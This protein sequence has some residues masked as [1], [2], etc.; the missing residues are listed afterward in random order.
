ML[1]LRMLHTAEQVLVKTYFEELSKDKP[2]NRR[3]LTALPQRQIRIPDAIITT[4]M[5]E[6]QL[7][8]VM[9]TRAHETAKQPLVNAKKAEQGKTNKYAKFKQKC[10]VEDARDPRLQREVIPIV[11]ESHGAAAPATIEH[12]A[13][14]RHH[15]GHLVLPVEDNSSTQIFFSTWTHQVSTALQLGNANMIHNIPLGNRCKSRLQGDVQ[16][17]STQR[18]V[19]KYLAL[20]LQKDTSDD[21]NSKSGESDTESDGE[22]APADE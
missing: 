5:G 14:M 1:L 19:E 3:W 15:F 20:R 17:D 12:M 2:S 22:L 6:T 8:D 4:P 13:L 11:F 9:I 7:T 18:D 16:V 21:S 10:E